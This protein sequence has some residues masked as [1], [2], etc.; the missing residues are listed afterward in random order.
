MLRNEPVVNVAAGKRTGP[1]GLKL[2]ACDPAAGDPAERRD[3]RPD[4]LPVAVQRLA[5]LAS[6]G[7]ED[8]DDDR[9]RE[10]RADH[11][12]QHH[13]EHTERRE[14]RL[15]ASRMVRHRGA[16][17]GCVAYRRSVAVRPSVLRDDARRGLR[18][19]TVRAVQRLRPRWLMVLPAC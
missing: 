2:G 16:V 8:R 17:G 1:H 14:P 4:R 11:H 6:A 3:V 7:S 9:E 12:N 18:A 19:P 5:A 13:A 10:N 15:S